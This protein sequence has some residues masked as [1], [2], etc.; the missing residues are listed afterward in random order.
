M[1]QPMKLILKQYTMTAMSVAKKASHN[2]FFFPAILSFALALLVGF[3]INGSSI[4]I[5]HQIFYGDRHD[6]NLLINYPQPIRSDEWVV[7]T[8]KTIGQ[9]KNGYQVINKN[10]GLGEDQSILIGGP[11]TDWSTLFRPD[12]VSFFILPFDNAFALKWWLPAY[13]L[14]LAVYFFVLVFLPKKRLLASVIA[15]A[16]LF[17]PFVQWWGAYASI[18]WALIGFVAFTK[19]FH[20]R[21]K[22]YEW[23]WG[24]LFS[25]AAVGFAITLYPPFQIPVVFMIVA[26][27]I[28]YTIDHFDEIPRKNL[29]RKGA[30]LITAGIASIIIFLLFMASHK[31]VTDII[32]NSA[33]PGRRIATSGGYNLAHLLASQT[34]SILQS[35][36]AAAAYKNFMPNQSEASN[37]ILIIPYLIL[38]IV[39]VSWLGFKKNRHICYS[40]LAPLLL[41]IFF[42]A[43]LFVPGLD[44]LGKVS[45]LSNVP[46][47]RLI[48][49]FG[50]LNLICLVLFIKLYEDTE[51][52]PRHTLIVIY[53]LLIVIVTLCINFY[54]KSMLPGFM[55]F[56]W[57]LILS[58]PFAIII[59]FL[60]R[61]Q[62]I[63]AV[64]VFCVFSFFSIYK[65]QPLYIGTSVLQDS[66]I[67]KAMIETSSRYNPEQ[68]WV[69]DYLYLE[70]FPAMNG[71]PSLSGTY[72]YPQIKIWSKLNQPEKIDTYNRYA[73]IN[74]TFDRNA[75]KTIKPILTNPG[76][77]QVNIVIEPC[78]SF[79]KSMNVGYLYTTTKFET[80]E[81]SCLTLAKK[82]YYPAISL[83]IYRVNI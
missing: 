12:N 6:P 78:D 29:A 2:V 69:G 25:Y 62:Y 8:E 68:R 61:K 51:Q 54:I 75:T 3:S 1:L 16:F 42:A 72:V 10:I 23:L 47:E 27:T 28:G 30:I 52:Q 71:L 56:R 46:V 49:G 64:G 53:T 22:A 34:S 15:L 36:T 4:G 80:E 18:A 63:V 50:V 14:T 35:N 79:F 7:S 57:A 60:L 59:Y 33:Y 70:N 45:L 38:P 26:L 40:L 67:S 20:E 44:L 9:S 21:K 31:T 43:W 73:H 77:D 83:Y 32:Q 74:F 5:Y 65:I 81:A 11:T 37:F 19:L 39:Y 13:L 24:L 76:T 66:D 17:S 82:V 58:L 48:I 41:G 55:S